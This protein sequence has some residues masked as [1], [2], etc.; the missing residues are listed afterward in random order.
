[1]A[2]AVRELRDAGFLIGLHTSGAYPRRLR[3][4]LPLLDWVGIDVKAPPRLYG[5][6]SG[7]AAVVPR[8]RESLELLQGYG[9]VFEVR[10]TLH[11]ALDSQAFL[12]LA[13][14]LGDRGIRTAALQTRH[15]AD[16]RKLLRAHDLPERVL[17][18][19]RSQVDNLILRE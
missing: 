13:A 11:P 6:V 2:E 1:V 10:T 14:L 7:S 16:P 18:G 3:R 19:W 5:T 12:E 4:L 9:T 17:D 15:D 8:V